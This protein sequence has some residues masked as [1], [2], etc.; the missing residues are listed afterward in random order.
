MGVLCLCTFVCLVWIP[1]VSPGFGDWGLGCVFWLR[2][3]SQS[4]CSEHFH[5]SCWLLR[6]ACPNQGKEQS[7]AKVTNQLSSVALQLLA[8][9][10]DSVQAACG[11][12]QE[13]MIFFERVLTSGLNLN[14]GFA[15]WTVSWAV[16]AGSTWDT[17]PLLPSQV[18]LRCC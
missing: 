8:G 12:P 13:S 14:F 1:S 9:E 2:V 5:S 10:R 4:V 17:L 3:K 15:L 7:Q 18:Q 16:G 6:C 11:I